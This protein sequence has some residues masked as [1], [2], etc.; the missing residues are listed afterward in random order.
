MNHWEARYRS[1]A[2]MV[3]SKHVEAAE[4]LVR[5][6]EELGRT[7]RMSTFE[8]LDCMV[9]AANQAQKMSLTQHANSR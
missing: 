1:I 7:T 2:S 5:A 6:A 9:Y 4:K 3:D 8:A